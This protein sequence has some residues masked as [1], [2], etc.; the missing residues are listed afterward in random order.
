MGRRNTAFIPRTLR[1][2]LS[3]SQEASVPPP[4]IKLIQKE[5]DRHCDLFPFVS[6]SE[7]PADH[8]KKP[9]SSRSPLEAIFL[10]LKLEN[11]TGTSAKKHSCKQCFHPKFP[12]VPLQL[13][14]GSLKWTL[15]PEMTQ[16]RPSDLSEFASLV[17]D[18]GRGW[19]WCGGVCGVWI[20]K[21]GERGHEATCITSSSL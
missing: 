10:A 19:G 13:G 21:C 1:A 8:R 11:E 17:A 12:R 4:P 5:R 2:V 7:I 9:S 6:D 15:T 18:G 3:L 14:R 20:S 16:A